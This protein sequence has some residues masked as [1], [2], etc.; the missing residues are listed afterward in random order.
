MSTERG[1]I[2]LPI[3]TTT[4]EDRGMNK[5]SHILDSMSIPTS[6]VSREETKKMWPGTSCSDSVEG[7]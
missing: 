5:T 3:Y 7:H 2:K 6:A 1:D 4:T